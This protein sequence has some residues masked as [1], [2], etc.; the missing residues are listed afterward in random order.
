MKST[1]TPVTAMWGAS[2]PTPRRFIGN[3]HGP[4]RPI[5]PTAINDA[6]ATRSGRLPRA[7]S[8]TPTPKAMVSR[9]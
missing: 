2:P 6:A 3:S 1:I 9:S 7:D 5:A 4:G 8:Q